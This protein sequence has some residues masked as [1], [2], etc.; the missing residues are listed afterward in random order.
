MRGERILNAGRSKFRRL[1]L[2]NSRFREM[3]LDD[4]DVDTLILKMIPSYIQF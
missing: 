4:N 3:E 1:V 2:F